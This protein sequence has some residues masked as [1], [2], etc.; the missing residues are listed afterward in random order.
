MSCIYI[1]P[2]SSSRTAHALIAKL[3]NLSPHKMRNVAT[4]A[5]LSA[6][7]RVHDL[8]PQKPLAAKKALI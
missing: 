5:K 2:R 8:T 7:I 6:K 4:N 3:K 1:R